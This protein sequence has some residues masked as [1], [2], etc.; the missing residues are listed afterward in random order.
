V[1]D[2]S[3]ESTPG[4]TSQDVTVFVTSGDSN[5]GVVAV[6]GTLVRTFEHLFNNVDE[7]CKTA[8]L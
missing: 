3:I 4:H 1:W 6:A 5:L 8:L 2:V 7:Y